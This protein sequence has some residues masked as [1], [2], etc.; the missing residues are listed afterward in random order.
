MSCELFF[1]TDFACECPLP[2]TIVQMHTI[3]TAAC[4]Y[5]LPQM[6]VCQMGARVV[7]MELSKPAAWGACFCRQYLEMQCQS[8]RQI[9]DAPFL[10]T[11]DEGP[12]RVLVEM[13]FQQSVLR[14][15]A[16]P[17]C[18]GLTVVPIQRCVRRF[19]N[20][21]R[22]LRQKALYWADVV[23]RM[24][25][26]QTA[27]AETLHP[28]HRIG[29]NEDLMCMILHALSVRSFKA[30]PHLERSSRPKFV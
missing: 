30:T 21:R 22:A 13:R 26:K 25:A 6:R 3:K 12:K 14:M 18:V 28:L 7:R 4:H 29:S 24:C 9:H 10:S 20:Y 11:N 8:V 17:L 27:A 19:V 2:R 15:P 1:R 23:T 16:I 5:Y